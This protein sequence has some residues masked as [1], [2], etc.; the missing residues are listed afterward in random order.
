MEMLD[1]K[2]VSRAHWIWDEKNFCYICSKCH[3]DFDYNGSYAIFDHNAA[4]SYCPN[5]GARMRLD[6]TEVINATN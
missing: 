5:C 2:D 3:Y 1:K 4:N 6:K